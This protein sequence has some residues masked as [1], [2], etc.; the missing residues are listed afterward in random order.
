MSHP[1]EQTRRLRAAGRAIRWL[2]RGRSPVEPELL[3]LDQLLQPGAVCC[4]VGAA[5]GLYTLA[6]ADRVGETGRVHSFEP[7]PGPNAV[8]RR[9]VRLAGA[10]NV[11]VPRCALGVTPR[12]ATMS[13][14]KRHGLPVHGRAFVA[15]R[16][17]GLGSNS[18]F[19]GETRLRVPITTL[20]R[21]VDTLDLPRLDLIKVDVEGAEPSV[22][23]GAERTLRRFRPHVMLEIESRHLER[24]RTDPVAVVAG[25]RDRGYAMAVLEAG[26]W[27][28]VQE[29]TSASRNY[30][31]SPH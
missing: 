9:V 31:F 23:A 19:D 4:D 1:P 16:A 28:P 3:G 13:L 10:S 29:V 30:L 7:L 15:D 5:F 6:F 21:V 12:E 17:D 26:R 11:R 27:R 2:A 8:L 14:P 20:D 24:F 25:M 18:E 22:L